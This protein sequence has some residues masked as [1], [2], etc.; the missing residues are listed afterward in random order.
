M[1]TYSPIC[2][3]TCAYAIS[4]NI[5]ACIYLK[6]HFHSSIYSHFLYHY[7]GLQVYADL[8]V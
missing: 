8:H 1:F 6:L 3:Y 2:T 5:C 4:V 7:V